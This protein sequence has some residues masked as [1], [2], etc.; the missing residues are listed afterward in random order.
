M[1]K[2]LQHLTNIL[3]ISLGIRFFSM[4]I[5]L[6][7]LSFYA[8]SLEGG[9]PALT[10]Y[11]LGIFGLTQAI[12]QIPLGTLSDKIGFKK[13][14]IMGLILLIAGLLTAA[15]ATS[16]YWFIFAR[17]LQGSGAIVT[18]GYSWISSTAVDTDR[19]KE[20]TRLGAIIGIFTMLS[21]TI[22]PLLHIFMSISQ[23]FL[24]SAFL[25]F[26]CTIWIITCTHQ[27][28][29]EKRIQYASEEKKNKNKSVFNRTNLSLGLL[30]TLNGILMLAFFFTIPLLMKGIMET[31]EMWKI[32]TPSILISIGLLPVF[33]KL[34]I[35]YNPRI[36][37]IFLFILE[38]LGFVLLFKGDITQLFAGT[39]FIMTGSFSVSTLIPMLANR[40][41]HNSQR[42]KGNGIILSM[43]YFGSFLGAITTGYFWGISKL[44][45]F[46]FA[47]IIALLGILLIF[48]I[49]FNKKSDNNNEAK[50]KFNHE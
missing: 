43:Q 48:S 22:G 14:M 25:V 10:G 27:V 21:Y 45:T 15:F 7:F 16:V 46:T 8:L 1:N 20:L 6:P 35:H 9:N 44:C 42:G 3:S 31:E 17:A 19:D 38:G 5:V 50:L 47:W 40:N 33:S 12:F 26:C 23:M 39:A 29:P 32:L 28:A 34:I 41:I 2:S 4:K 11:A 49:S 30:L 13:V 37:L 24:F 18:V 36:I